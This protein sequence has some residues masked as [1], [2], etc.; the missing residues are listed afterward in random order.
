MTVNIDGLNINYKV[1]GSGD[2]VFLLHG[3]GANLELF[4]GVAAAISEKYTVVAFDFPGFG[5][6]EEP[7]EPWSVSDYA[8]LTI[9]FIN[10]FGCERVI[11]LGHSFGGRVIIKMLGEK[12]L[13]FKVYKIVLVDSA[14]IMPKRSLA[15]KIRVDI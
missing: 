7:G 15:Y 10:S 3:W 2:Y 13:P 9:K 8:D 1:T 5:Q 11:L 4:E 12:A 6:S 14:G